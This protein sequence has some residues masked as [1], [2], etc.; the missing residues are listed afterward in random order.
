MHL[1]MVV[2]G[3]PPVVPQMVSVLCRLLR[4]PSRLSISR[5]RLRMLRLG[6]R[7]CLLALWHLGTRIGGRS[8]SRSRPGKSPR[9]AVRART[10]YVH[11]SFVPLSCTKAKS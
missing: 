7:L 11:R 8:Q 4:S 3:V 2:K 9:S 1:R 6:L 5:L 10:I